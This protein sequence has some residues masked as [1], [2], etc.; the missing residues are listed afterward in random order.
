MTVHV[1]HS[2]RVYGDRTP[3][4]CD[5]DYLD[6]VC[7]ELVS[8]AKKASESIAIYGL[9]DEE[10]N[11]L[12]EVACKNGRFADIIA[13]RLRRE[14]KYEAIDVNTETSDLDKLRSSVRD[15]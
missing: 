8:M 7:S 5:P 13:E 9:T 11:A 10:G 15:G 4:L 12:F 14:G 3:Y 1:R 2:V 6:L